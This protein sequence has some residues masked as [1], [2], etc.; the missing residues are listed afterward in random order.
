MSTSRGNV[1]RKRPQKHQNKTAFKNDLHDTSKKTKLLNSLEISG[2]CKRCKDIIDWKIKYKKYKT[3]TAPGKC[4][5]CGQK[6]VK[7]AYHVM[8]SKCGADKN[9]CTKC[10]KHPEN[11]EGSMQSNAESIL[12]TDLEAMLKMLPERK[13]RSI[14]RFINKHD[15]GEN[16]IT[17]ELMSHIE[18]LT[19][20]INNTNIDDDD[21][22]DFLSDS[23][24]EK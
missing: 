11:D 23:D 19:A 22:M 21:D 15:D 9:V 13:R 18:E 14:L 24:E 7:H 5:A 2:L 6:T 16:K 10:C 1:S 12:N 20:G 4:V 17:P 3:L 8:C